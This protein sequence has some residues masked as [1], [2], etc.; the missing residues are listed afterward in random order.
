VS[1]SGYCSDYLDVL[2]GSPQG[3]KLGPVLW[4]LY[5]NDLNSKLPDIQC[6][7][8]AD[9][10]TFYSASS[11]QPAIDDAVD[12]AHKNSMQLNANKTVVLKVSFSDQSQQACN[13]TID[14]TVLLSS[15]VVKFLGIFIDSKLSFNEHVQQ[16]ISKS[17]SRLYFMRLL[18]RQGLDSA[19][20]KTYYISNIHTIIT[21]ASTAWFLLC[22]KKNQQLLEQVQRHATRIIAPDIHGYE[23]RLRALGLMTL[24]VFIMTSSQNHFNSILSNPE[25]PLHERLSFN[26]GRTSSRKPQ[27]FRPPRCRTT[28]RKDSFFIHFMEKYDK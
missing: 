25:H 16:L 4:L 2:V 26:T 17:N 6:I 13:L 22:S 20:L 5:S 3:T 15:P 9:D 11:V 18:R 10:T 14:S 12:W 1:I 24:E 8:Y 28:K 27:T 21:Y 7:K 19:G 23:E